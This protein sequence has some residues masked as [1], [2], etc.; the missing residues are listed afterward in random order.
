MF[1]HSKHKTN[2][3]IYKLAAVAAD[4]CMG[5]Q[6]CGHMPDSFYNGNVDYKMEGVI[7]Y[8]YIYIYIHMFKMLKA[9]QYTMYIVPS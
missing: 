7:I 9:F 4:A 8:I 2:K 6:I 1:T 5:L 3:S